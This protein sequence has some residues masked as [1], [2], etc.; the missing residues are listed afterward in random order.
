MNTDDLI[1][2]KVLDKRNI[3]NNKNIMT[4]T[5]FLNGYE[6]LLCLNSLKNDYNYVTLGGFEDLE[7]QIIVFYPDYIEKENIEYP[8]DML[9][10]N[11][12]QKMSHRDILGSLMGI[13]IKRET[14]GDI[15]TFDDCAYVFC[16]KEITD[17]ILSNLFKIGRQ[18]VNIEI[19]NIS[20]I[21]GLEEDF[22]LIKDTVASVRLDSV[23]SSGFLISRNK[24]CELIKAS[25]V[26]LNNV[27]CVKSDQK[28]NVLDKISIRGKGKIILNE[29]LGKSKK[30]RIFIEIKKYI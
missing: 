7:R 28:V 15:L 6:L 20:E 1:V 29:I 8:I 10:I 2:S 13:G 22:K 23:V 30:D 18:S 17:Y 24:A 26:Y 11:L 21:E 9:K 4:N 27:I 5:K 12:K 14:I 25:N 16:L 3:C 19:T